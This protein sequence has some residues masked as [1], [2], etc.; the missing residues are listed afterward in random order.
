MAHFSLD[1]IEAAAHFARLSVRQRNATYWPHATLTACLGLLG[2]LEDAQAALAELLARKPDYGV[3]RARADFF[4]AR[5]EFIGR[6]A[7]GLLRAGAPE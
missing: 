4:F 7:D 5:D 2:R 1:E 6:Y 3:A